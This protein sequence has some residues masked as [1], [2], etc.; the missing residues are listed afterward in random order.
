MLTLIPNS[1]KLLS[2]SWKSTYLHS[3]LYMAAHAW[4]LSIII[5]LV[6]E[7]QT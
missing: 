4:N 2:W 1:K 7:R 5:I 3:Y 6:K